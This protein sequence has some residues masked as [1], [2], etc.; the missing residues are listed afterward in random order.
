MKMR[1]TV[2]F[3]GLATVF[4]ASAPVA[5]APVSFSAGISI[6]SPADFYTPLA[7]YGAWVDVPRYGRCWHPSHVAVGWEPYTVGYW[8]WTD[9]GW[10]W[11][12]DEPWAWACYHYGSWEFDPSYGWV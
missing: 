6:S 3:A 10:Y 5:L 9:A 7:S 4:L 1:M 12:S 11:Q 2:L 8:E